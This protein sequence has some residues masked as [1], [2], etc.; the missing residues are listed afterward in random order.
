[1][2]TDKAP[3]SF[4][5]FGSIAKA[6]LQLSQAVINQIKP[7]MCFRGPMQVSF[8]FLFCFSF[9]LVLSLHRIFS[10]FHCCP[11]N[12]QFIGAR[13]LADSLNDVCLLYTS[14]SPRDS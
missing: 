1:M 3:K 9:A 13:A 7:D 12:L 4:P 5:E 14:P 8:Y 10:K 2:T 6:G 11:G